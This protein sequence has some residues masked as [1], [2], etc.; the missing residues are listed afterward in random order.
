MYTWGC[1][2]EGALG[3]TTSCED[4]NFSAGEVDGISGKVVQISAGDCHSAALTTDG[5]VYAWGSFR[6]RELL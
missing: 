5:T 2:D 3:R 6:V 4:D 1:N